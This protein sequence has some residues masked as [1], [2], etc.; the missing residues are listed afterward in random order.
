MFLL[1]DIVRDISMI[2]KMKTKTTSQDRLV[3]D[4][5]RFI[6]LNV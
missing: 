5:V 2:V 1:L 4:I 6:R 3:V